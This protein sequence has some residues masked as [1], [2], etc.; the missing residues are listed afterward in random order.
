MN[1]LLITS[2]YPYSPG[3]Y[4][5]GGTSALHNIVKYWQQ[6]EGVQLQVINPTYIYLAECLGIKRPARE[7]R[8]RIT[9]FQLDQVPVTVFPIIKLPRLAYLYWPLYRYLDR[10]LKQISF[11]PDIVVAH[12]DKGLEI[13]FGYAQR[14]GL[15]LVAGLHIAPDIRTGDKEAFMKRCHHII[16]YAS[17]IACR[18]PFI[19]RRIKE[20][21]PRFHDKSFVVYSGIEES[22]IQPLESGLKRLRQ[23]KEAGSNATDKTPV[24][25]IVT[26]CHLL[27][28]KHVHTVMKALA[29]I[30]ELPWTY[31]VIG[32][33]EERQSLEA[34][35]RQLEIDQRVEFT[36]VK[37]REE[38]LKI[39]A[40]S[41]IFIMI[42][43]METFGL[44]Y[45]ES[46]AS[47][48][49]V[50]GTKGEG[51]DGFIQDGIN[52]FLLPAGEIDPLKNRLQEIITQLPLEKLESILKHSY[53]TISNCTDQKTGLDYY[54]Q[55]IKRNPGNTRQSARQ[56]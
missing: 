20:W 36:G 15:P 21:Y 37:P 4:R 24:I 32:D 43:H 35:A 16:E 46:M 50:I 31:T 22:A 5:P 10:Y 26:V 18:S 23:W 25:S 30:K 8:L 33:G 52:G 42:S 12:Y 48:N 13:G 40:S 2:L 27:K 3:T 38:V 45:M 44:V 51:I 7:K 49:I 34:L 53:Q 14:R 28:Q 19:H 41:H 54:N 1:I 55:I 17:A 56:G 11:T 6:Q 29:E 9:G 47:G 39:L